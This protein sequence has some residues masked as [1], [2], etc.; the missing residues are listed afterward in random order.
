LTEGVVEP[1]SLPE[2]PEIKEE[3]NADTGNTVPE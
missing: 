2:S 1:N 3:D